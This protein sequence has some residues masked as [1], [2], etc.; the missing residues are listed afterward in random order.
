MTNWAQSLCDVG[1]G[2]QLYLPESSS[3][4]VQ[5]YLLPGPT[6]VNQEWQLT[7]TTISDIR[8]GTNWPVP[9]VPGNVRS[10]TFSSPCTFLSG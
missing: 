4:R 2:L 3:G 1:C 5:V 9:Y 6:E 8:V 10:L 7:L